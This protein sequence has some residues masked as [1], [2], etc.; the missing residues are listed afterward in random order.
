MQ[1]RK[2]IIR[3]SDKYIT[4][5]CNLGHILESHKLD[6]NFGGSMLEA[7]WSFGEL[8][9]RG[10]RLAAKCQGFGH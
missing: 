10:N 9:E 1:E 8:Q 6:E 2:A 3:V 4:V 5:L 7:D